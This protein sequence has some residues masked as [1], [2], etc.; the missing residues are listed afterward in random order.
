MHNQAGNSVARSLSGRK[1][2]DDPDDIFQTQTL[3][4]QQRSLSTAQAQGKHVFSSLELNWQSAYSYSLQNEPDIQYFTNRYQPDIELYFIKPSSDRIPSRFYRKMNQGNWSNRLDLTYSLKQWD[5]LSTKIKAGA[6]YLYKQREFREQRYSFAANNTRYQGDLNSYFADSNMVI[7]NAGENQFE[8]NGQGLYLIDNLDPANNYDADQQ[9]TA[10]YAMTD[11]PLTRRLRLIAGLRMEH[12]AIRLRSFSE[13]VLQRY[14]SVDGQAKLLNNLDFLP[15]LNMI[16]DFSERMKLRASYSRTLARP[17]FR[18]LAPFASFDVEGGYILVGNPDLQR[19]LIDNVDLR[20]EFYPSASEVVS[21]S[22][23]YKHFQNPIE[24]TFNPEQ[25]NGEFTFR[26]VASAFLYGAEFELRHNLS[27]WHRA[28]A[29]FTLA[30]NF[31]YVYSRTQ[32][33]PRELAQMR[34]ND[35]D[36]ADTR[37][38]FGQSPYALNCLLSYQNQKGTNANLAFNVAGARIAYIT[39]G[40]TPEIYELPRPWLNFNFSQKVYKGLHLTFSANNLLLTQYQEVL[41]FKGQ[42]YQT[43]ANPLGAVI[44]FGIKYK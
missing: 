35:L 2:R 44:S 33:D 25:P 5:G 6:A 23:F 40:A 30:T 4:Y 26:N 19:S 31:S 36:A 8:R 9:V 34:A 28:L 21:V 20:W 14:P 37:A 32:I 18:E 11:L 22:A 3:S 15:S 17:S 12:T 42:V 27:R 39:I 7:W 41:Q 1:F 24:R 13:V 10:A 16:Y 38:M 29:P 43:Q